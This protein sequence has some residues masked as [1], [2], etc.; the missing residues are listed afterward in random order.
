MIADV[1]YTTVLEI[2]SWQHFASP[3]AR[4]AVKDDL[5]ILLAIL[6]HCGEWLDTYPQPQDACLSPGFLRQCAV[7]LDNPELP[8]PNFRRYTE[9]A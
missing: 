9:N 2:E 6:K 1:L 3:E 5:K 8:I 4:Q 7:W